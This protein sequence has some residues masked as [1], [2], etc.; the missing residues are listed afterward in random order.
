MMVEALDLTDS[1][2]FKIWDV[3]ALSSLEINQVHRSKK[4]IY[5]I[6]LF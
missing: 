4:F 2:V 6:Y 5:V 3:N 1:V